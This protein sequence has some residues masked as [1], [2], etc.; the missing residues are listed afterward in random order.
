MLLL[1]LNK[2]AGEW[3][4]LVNQAFHVDFNKSII[5]LKTPSISGPILNF[6]A[7]LI[8]NEK[9][10]KKITAVINKIVI[11]PANI[12]VIPYFRFGFNQRVSINRDNF[13]Y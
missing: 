5:I 4:K 7:K 3:Q 1:G 13:F 9:S 8:L 12:R 2:K 11:I 10:G 6:S